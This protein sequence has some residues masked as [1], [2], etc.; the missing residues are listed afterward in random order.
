MPPSPAKL[1]TNVAYLVQSGRAGEHALSPLWAGARYVS[2]SQQA[3][4]I[5]DDLDNRRLSKS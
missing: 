4:A 5:A 3:V 1:I 2:L